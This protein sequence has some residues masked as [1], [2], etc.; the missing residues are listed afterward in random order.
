MRGRGSEEGLRR[1]FAEQGADLVINDIVCSKGLDELASWIRDKGR[2]VVTVQGDVSQRADVERI[3]DRAWAELGPAD[4][5]VNNA[6][7]ET[8]VPFLELT[9]EQWQ[10]CNRYQS[11]ERMDVL[12]KLLSARHR[13]KP[14][15]LDCKHR[16][17]SGRQGIAGTNSLCSQQAC[18]RGAHA[19]CLCRDGRSMEFA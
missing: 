6:G 19:Q 12:P 7:I 2:R 15:R 13:R 14:Q 16:F 8:I 4:I 11:E 10:R 9:E 17:H 18:G 3:F 1:V 5:L